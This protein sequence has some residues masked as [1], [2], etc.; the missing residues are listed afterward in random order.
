MP[1][2]RAA[3][4]APPLTYQ[5]TANPP[6][7]ITAAFTLTQAHDGKAFDN[8]GAAGAIACP[9]TPGLPIGT[10]FELYAT[11]AFSF[12]VTTSGGETIQVNTTAGATSCACTVKGASMRL[13]K[14][15]STGW[16]LV[17]YVGA[18]G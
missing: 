4:T 18:V 15:T 9:I 17:W 16:G 1:T 6:T 11:D 13:R 5:G 10:A 12:G 2:Q 14:Q 8:H 3:M 7:A